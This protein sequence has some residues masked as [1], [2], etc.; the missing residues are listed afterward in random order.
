MEREE[1]WSAVDDKGE[2]RNAFVVACNWSDLKLSHI[3]RGMVS[4][5]ALEGAM[6][7]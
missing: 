5:P 7:G 6:L 2:E 4:N 1:K 3:K